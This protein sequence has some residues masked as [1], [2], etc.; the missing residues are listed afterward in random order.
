MPIENKYD[1]AALLT[2]LSQDSAYAF[3]LCFDTY[4]NRVYTVA[5]SY[6]KEK[7]LAEET[8]QEV[9]LKLWLQRKELTELKSLQAWLFTV[10]KNHLINQ[11][12]KI[13]RE[14]K[15]KQGW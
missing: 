8:V 14:Y 15:A 5:L 1:E 7:T 9:F 12:A 3:Q 4:R 6:L 13:A 2:M 11:L 10:A